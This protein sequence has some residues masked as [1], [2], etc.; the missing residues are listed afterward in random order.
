MIT[1]F[2]ISYTQCPIHGRIFFIGI[3]F[4]CDQ[5]VRSIGERSVHA[6][7][8]LLNKAFSDP[9]CHGAQAVGV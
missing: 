4:I 1:P 3:D 5:L 2:A 7:D 6:V 8:E 9:T